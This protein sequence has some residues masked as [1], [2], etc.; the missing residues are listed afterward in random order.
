M[1]KMSLYQLIYMYPGIDTALS[2]IYVTIRFSNILN[3]KTIVSKKNT[4]THT[5]T[6]TGNY[7]SKYLR[8]VNQ[9]PK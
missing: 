7:R 3:S 6:H 9:A 1:C 2:K 8:H 5:Y 4:L